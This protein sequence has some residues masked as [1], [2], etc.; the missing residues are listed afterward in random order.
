MRLRT[1]DKNHARQ[2]GIA[3]KSFSHFSY[4]N[5]FAQIGTVQTKKRISPTPDI[6]VEAITITARC[7]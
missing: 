6:C 3:R 2:V 5:A 1:T 7:L 4:R